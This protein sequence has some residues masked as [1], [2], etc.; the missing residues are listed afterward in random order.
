MNIST[1]AL[2]NDDKFIFIAMLAMAADDLDIFWN[3]NDQNPDLILV[4]IEQ[5]EGKKF[6]LKYH[7][8]KQLI[9]FAHENLVDAPWFL[10]KP[11]QLEKLKSLLKLVSE[12]YSSDDQVEIEIE[13]EP[14]VEVIPVVEAIPVVEVIPVVEAIPVVETIPIVETNEVFDPSLFLTG[15]LLK[16]ETLCIKVANFAPLYFLP[17]QKSCFSTV[18]INFR[19]LDSEQLK[20]FEAEISQVETETLAADDIATRSDLYKYPIEGFLWVTTLSSSKGRLLDGISAD[21]TKILLKQWPDF[22]I[23]VHEIAHIRLAAIMVRRSLTL[24]SLADRTQI[25]IETV[26][27]FFNACFITQLVEIDENN[28][29]ILINNESRYSSEQHSIFK[30]ILNKLT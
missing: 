22:S 8:D 12:N 20:F 27:N 18:D 30:S 25:P 9:A 3:F 17:E 24:R 23:L 29:E 2:E 5:V 13:K 6:W 19:H 15:V 11:V 21:E 10:E 16:S 1:N 26:V 4:D 7:I 14:I 28:H